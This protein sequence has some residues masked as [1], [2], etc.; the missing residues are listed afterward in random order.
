MDH[1]KSCLPCTPTPTPT[2]KYSCHNFKFLHKNA[3]NDYFKC[4]RTVFS[5]TFFTF[6]FSY[7]SLQQV[8][9]ADTKGV[10]FYD[11][12]RRS[13]SV[14]HLTTLIKWVALYQVRAN[15]KDE[16]KELPEVRG[17]GSETRPTVA[18]GERERSRTLSQQEASQRKGQGYR[19]FNSSRERGK[20][21]WKFMMST[22]VFKNTSY[23]L[24]ANNRIYKLD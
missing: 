4:M 24:L 8:S 1:P 12:R 17:V 9:G 19:L 13:T 21:S 2:T 3:W 6:I 18:A 5:L 20:K 22:F 14:F 23:S 15:W 16:Q 10:E 7:H 11:F